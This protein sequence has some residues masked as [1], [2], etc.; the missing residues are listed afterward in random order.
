MNAIVPI[1]GVYIINVL[2]NGRNYEKVV[3][4]R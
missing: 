1:S 4:I 3:R 2:I